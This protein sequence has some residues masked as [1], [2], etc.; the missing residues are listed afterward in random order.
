MGGEFVE[1]V[2]LNADGKT[3]L[4]IANST[5]GTLSLVLN[6]AIDQASAVNGVYQFAVSEGLNGLA[7]GDLNSDGL[8]DIV[9]LNGSTQQ[10]SIFL[11]QKPKN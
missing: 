8:P 3:D 4:V 7:T 5:A 2:D 10:I 9:I 1:A 11:S 6:G